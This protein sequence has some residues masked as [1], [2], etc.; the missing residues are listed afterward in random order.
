MRASG[1]AVITNFSKC[2]GDKM[3]YYY[4]PSKEPISV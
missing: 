1:I 3:K 2:V 4:F